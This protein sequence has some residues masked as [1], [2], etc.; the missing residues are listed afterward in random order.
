M[1]LSLNLHQAQVSPAGEVELVSKAPVLPER[2]HS[3]AIE[4]AP[5]RNCVLAICAILD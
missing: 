3:D 1:N 2:A 5:L 4:P